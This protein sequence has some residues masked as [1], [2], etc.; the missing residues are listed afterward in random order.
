MPTILQKERTERSSQVWC[1]EISQLHIL[2]KHFHPFQLTPAKSKK[3]INS[4]S[5]ITI[6]NK[7]PECYHLELFLKALQPDN[8]ALQPPDEETRAISRRVWGVGLLTPDWKQQSFLKN[9]LINSQKNSVWCHLPLMLF[10]MRFGW[11][12]ADSDIPDRKLQ[13]TTKYIGQT[14]VYNIQ[15]RYFI[16][17]G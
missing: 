2:M 6:C 15:K 16:F 10:V 8:Y 14:Y 17:P 13:Y 11:F 9:V 3:K 4:L 5:I 1:G 7:A 12:I